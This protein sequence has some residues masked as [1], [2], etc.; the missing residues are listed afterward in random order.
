M[1]TFPLKLAIRKLQRQKS[2]TL[3]NLGGLSISLAACIVIFVYASYE[4]GFDKKIP[5]HERTYRII[6][7][8][9]DG[10]YWSRSFACYPDALSNRPEIENMTSFIHTNNNEIRV[11]ESDY[12]VSE[13]IIADTAFMD[14][15][16]VQCI[17]GRKEDL[18]LPNTVFLDYEL[19]ERLFPGENAYGQEIFL[20]Q[21]EGNA[22]DSLGLFTVA[23]II[24]SFPE[25]THF[26]FQMIFS[27]KGNLNGMINHM[28]EGKF[29]SANVY[30]RLF[31][32]DKV[33]QLEVDLTDVLVPFLAKSHGPPVEAFN[34]R[35]QPVREIHFTTDLNREP[36]PVI[37]KSVLY[38]LFSVGG[39][40]LILMCMN[41]LSTAIVQAL[42]QRKETGIMRTLGASN[43]ELFTVSLSKIFIFV[44][45]GLVLS[46][47][48]IFLAGT[49]LEVIFGS[50]WDPRKSITRILLFSLAAGCFVIIVAASG[51]HLMG[52]RISVVELLKGKLPSGGKLFGIFGVLTVVQFG[53]VVFLIG[54]SMMIG[55]QLRFMDHKDL[56]YTSENVYIARIPSPEPR[57]S[58]LLEEIRRNASVISA[59][60]VHHHPA[61][62]FQ[63]MDFSVGQSQ[64]PFEFRMVDQDIFNTLEIELI[65]NFS[66]GQTNM[67][68]WV[69]NET[70]YRILVQDFSEEIVAG[71]NFNV[72]EEDAAEDGRS[73]FKIAGV[74]KDFHYGS[75]YDRIGPFAFAIRNPESL[76]NRWLVVRFRDG[77]PKAC[78]TAMKEM[79]E[80]HFP[81][82][83][84]DGFLLSEM[85]KNKYASSRKLSVIIRVFTLLSILIAG[86]G[87]YG[88]SLYITQQRTKEIGIR[89]VFGASQWQVNSMLNM[90]FLKWVAISLVVACPITLWALKKWLINFAYKATPSV[91]IFLLTGII[92]TAIAVISVTWQTA[93]AARRNPV[94]AI[95]YE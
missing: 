78:M 34:S 88:L 46:W 11:G 6:S 48:I 83:Q 39:L 60:T 42:R 27:Q 15:F 24:E 75:L 72:M 12:N 32:E 73:R 86:F 4:Q 77:Q 3:I 43:F 68:G 82:R 20:R 17:T 36:R 23:G 94:D 89:K 13:S 53:I 9:T 44:A 87:L 31:G 91:W 19:A 59:S 29:F 57:G 66:P 28:K 41:F 84:H 92:V 63:H 30:L 93:N 80:R 49:W 50:G 33:E 45:A 85:L 37:R 51:M 52:A 61:D 38:L 58:F 69:I 26:G 62:V 79:M 56:G 1:S 81:G 64:Y 70:F 18:G 22:N 14:F 47:F 40:I 2:F 8:L 10:I 74:M 71:S 67:E 95:R 35:L 16:D 7:R 5:D 54:F 25:N 21:F 55:K 76:Y 90:G 65:K